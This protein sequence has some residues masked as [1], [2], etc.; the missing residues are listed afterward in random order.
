MIHLLWL[1]LS[2]PIII[3]L[4][5]RRKAKPLPFSTLMFLRMVDQR[6]QRSYRLKEILLL[7]LRLAVLASLVGALE[8]PILR[9][10][11][12]KGTATPTTVANTTT[13]E[14]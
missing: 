10:K 5:F 12:F 3:H 4:V 13:V 8:R 1:S 6:V 7:L 2:I 11:S 9:S 14:T